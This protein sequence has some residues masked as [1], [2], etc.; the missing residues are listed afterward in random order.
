LTNE[1]W[2][3]TRGGNIADAGAEGPLDM[4]ALLESE[5]LQYKD[6]HRGDVIEGVVMGTDRDGILVNVGSKFE[7]VI[8]SHEMRSVGPEPAAR[9][10]VGE[11]VL[12]YVMQPETPDGQLLLSLDRARGEKGWRVLQQRFEEGQSFEA[13]VSGYNKGGLLVNVEGVHAFVPLSQ[14][15]GVRPERGEDGESSLAQMVGRTLHLKV[16]EINRRRNRVILSE[17]AALQEWRSQQKERLLSELTEGDIRRGK[18]SSIRSFGVF[19]DL[20]GADGLAHLSELSWERNKTPEDMFRVGDEIDV[21][22]MKVD[23]E[24]KKI[25]L[26][27]RR[28]QPELWEG[29]VDKYLVGQVV[30]GVITKLVTFGAFAR[31]EGPVEGLIHV[32]ELVDRRIAHPK[33]VVKEGDIV[34]LKIVRIEMD[35]HRLGLSL[36]RARDEGEAMGFVFSSTGEVE[37]VPE[38]LRAQ[39][40]EEAPPEAAP[41]AQPEAKAEPSVEAEVE[42]EAKA[43]VEAEPMAEIEAEAEAEPVTEAEAAEAVVEAKAEGEAEPEAEA[44]VEAEPEAEAEAVVEAEAEAEP[45]AEAEAAEAVVEAKAEAEAEPEAEAE[46]EAEP[47]AEAEAVVEAEAEAEPV[48]EVE[49]AEAVVEAKAQAEAEPEA[50]AEVEAEPEAEAEAVVEAEAEA[51]VKAEVVGEAQALAEVDEATPLEAEEEAL[52]GTEEEQTP[53]AGEK[54]ADAAEEEKSSLEG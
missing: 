36:R 25:A 19:V 24:T 17:R 54:D 43:E 3:E 32:S 50:E 18:I 33:E 7:G 9:L 37:D 5:G 39:L 42:A 12:V 45:V 48:T 2:Q 23:Q 52:A 14:V 4:G 10:N 1:P 35:R 6:L 20:G 13:Q 27:L 47:E 34:P 30:P 38:D 53:E 28:A 41:Q 21:Y 49:A 40:A 26:S 44:E 11:R 31:I 22:V 29:I 8:P 16:I 15:V 46:V 51:E